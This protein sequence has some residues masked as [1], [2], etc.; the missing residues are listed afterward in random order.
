MNEELN[1]LADEVMDSLQLLD[2]AIVRFIENGQPE[3]LSYRAYFDKNF[4]KAIHTITAI[5]DG[6]KEL[7]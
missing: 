1:A 4:E 3:L 6:I 5:N 2:E 7:G